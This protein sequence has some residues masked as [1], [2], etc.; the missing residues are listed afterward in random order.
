MNPILDAHGHIGSWADFLIPDPEP[1]GLVA[2]ADRVGVTAIGVSHLLAVGADAAAGNEAALAAA[3]EHPGRLGVWLVA[4][5]H[6]T[7]G[8]ERLAEQLAHPAVWGVKLHPDVHELRLDGPEYDPV[9]ALAAAHGVPVLSHGQT[10][11]EWSDPQLFA[12]LGRRHPDV[13]L[14]M[15]HT[16]LWQHGFARAARLVAEVPSV[17]LE[18]CGSRMTG[19]WVARLVELAGAERVVYGSDSCFLDLRVG[20]GRVLLAPLDDTDRAAVLGGNLRR[21][22][23]SRLTAEGEPR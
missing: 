12:A 8:L 9:F 17:S 19:R 6:Q 22:L 10:G 5:P 23:G 7:A 3:A 1:A 18:L 2:M 20:L 15:G 4:N 11:T 14:L 13:P 21:I 16:G